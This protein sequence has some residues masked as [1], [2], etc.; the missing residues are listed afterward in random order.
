[1]R[2]AYDLN[3][4]W[5]TFD[6]VMWL[7]RVREEY[8]P[9][10]VDIVVVDGDRQI[11]GRDRQMSRARKRARLENIVLPCMLRYV[12]LGSV[13]VAP[14][15]PADAHLFAISKEGWLDTPH[16][17]L[18]A[19]P[20]ALGHVHRLWGGRREVVTLTVRDSDIDPARNTDQA[21]ARMLVEDL[22]ACGFDVVV[23]PDTESVRRP[24]VGAE[25]FDA[26]AWSVDVRLAAYEQA[27]FNVF[28][29]GGPWVAAALDAGV[30]YAAFRMR[31][32]QADGSDD[33]CASAGYLTRVG[34]VDG[35][36]RGPYRRAWWGRDTRDYMLDRLLM[37]GYLELPHGEE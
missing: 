15:R 21:Q 19:S 6:C 23:V 22:K 29:T 1:M 27:A 28:T 2:V 18:R 17:V 3:H 11:T 32:E 4:H 13:T 30:R 5:A 14:E 33:V 36:S 20:W 16:D 37:H 10:P 31:V 25:V 9:E 12:H 26:A 7:V 24:D 34:L 35:H 8:G